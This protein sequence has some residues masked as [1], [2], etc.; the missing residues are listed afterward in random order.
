MGN[1][2][3][4]SGVDFII[5][6]FGVHRSKS[7]VLEKREKFCRSSNPMQQGATTA[8]EMGYLSS[9]LPQIPC[10][11]QRTSSKK[12]KT[13][14]DNKRALVQLS[15][16]RGAWQGSRGMQNRNVWKTRIIRFWFCFLLLLF[17]FN[18][19]SFLLLPCCRM[20]PLLE[21][22]FLTSSTQIPMV[23]QWSF[24]SPV[25]GVFLQAW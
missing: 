4:F 7:S 10:P 24:S 13:H 22:S 18:F 19:F 16:S 21:L 3:L 1:L 8:L 15:L 6:C 20:P 23:L 12:R 11:C 25:P 9:E 17:R 14:L 5:C 2:S